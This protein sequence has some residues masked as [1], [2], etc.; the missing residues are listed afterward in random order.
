MIKTEVLSYI[1]NTVGVVDPTQEYH[2]R[3]LEAVVESVLKEM[4]SDIYKLNPLLLDLY[5]KQYGVTTPVAIS[6]ENSTGIYYSTIPCKIINLPC[7][8]SGVRHIYPLVHTGNQFV[9]MDSRE[10]DLIFNTDIAIVTSKI[11][12]RTRQDTRVDYWNTNA[13]VRASGVR[14]DLLIPF[15]EYADTD[16]VMIPELTDAQGGTFIMRCLKVLQV[17]PPTDLSDD[18]NATQKAK[19]NTK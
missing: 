18:N 9:P 5:T 16:V 4:Y 7:K 19:Q 11:G 12:F 17:V 6:L 3:Y 15:S 14:M 1:K 2:L 13:A 10:A 8:S